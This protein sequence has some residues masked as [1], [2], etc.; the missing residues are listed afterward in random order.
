M[1]LG[2]W[3]L[4]LGLKILGLVHIRLLWVPLSWDNKRCRFPW[5]R[6]LS[7]TE[8]V[9]VTKG[10]A[11]SLKPKPQTPWT[12]A[13]CQVVGPLETQ[14]LWLMCFSIFFRCRG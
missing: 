13:S 6:E 5:P 10:I 1:N 14:H 9:E 7:N 2:C 12:S 8:E 11:S 4:G 3:V